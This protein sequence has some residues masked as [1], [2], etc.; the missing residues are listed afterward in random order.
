MGMTMISGYML[1]PLECCIHCK[2]KC[3]QGRVAF[4]GCAISVIVRRHAS[5]DVLRLQH[6]PGRYIGRQ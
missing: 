3:D 4:I 2:W 5:D 6:A 1:A